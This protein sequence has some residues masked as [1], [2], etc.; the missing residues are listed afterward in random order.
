[1]RSRFLGAVLSAVQLLQLA[2]ARP[3]ASGAPVTTVTVSINTAVCPATYGLPPASSPVVVPYTTTDANGNVIVGSSTSYALL[4]SS[5]PI[6]VLYATTDSV[7]NVYTATTTSFSTLPTSYPY[8]VYFPTTDAAGRVGVGSST[9][10]TTLPSPITVTATTTNA[11]GSIITTT[12][13]SS[14]SVPT[15]VSFT[16]E[17]YSPEVIVYTTTNAAGMTVTTSSTTAVPYT[18]AP[19][20][21]PYVYTNAAGVIVTGSTTSYLPYSSPAATIYFT[22][23]NPDGSV[24]TGSSISY[25]DFIYTPPGVGDRGGIITPYTTTLP[26][27]QVVVQF[28]TSFPPTTAPAT[29]SAT[30]SA[31]TSTGPAPGGTSA[32]PAPTTSVTVFTTTDSQGSIITT[33]STSVFTPSIAPPSAGSSSSAAASSGS[34][35]SSGS[36][37][38]AGS[39]LSSALGSAGATSNPAFVTSTPNS[40][41]S[42][43]VISSTATPSPSATGICTKNTTA[44]SPAPS[45]HAPCPEALGSSYESNN[46]VEWDLFCTVDF[47]MNDVGTAYATSLRDC[48]SY[49]DTYIPTASGTFGDLPCVAVTFAS[50]NPNGANCYLKSSITTASYGSDNLDSAKLH[51][52]NPDIANISVSA[53]SSSTTYS[54]AG[55]TGT[56]GSVTSL[57]LSTSS[58]S[59]PSIPPSASPS[60]S[61]SASPSASSGGS[62][63]N[64]DTTTTTTTTSTAPT[65][66]LGGSSSS[67]AASSKSP[68]AAA[69]SNSP[70]AAASSNSPAAAASSSSP[71]AASANG[72][73]AAAGSSHAISRSAVTVT[74]T[75]TGG[76]TA[77]TV[78]YSTVYASG[79]ATYTADSNNVV[80]PDAAY[81]PCGN[82]GTYSPPAASNG[83]PTGVSKNY[84]TV[85]GH[86]YN[87]YCGYV[88]SGDDL[89]NIPYSSSTFSDCISYCDTYTDPNAGQA[90][91]STAGTCVAANWGAYNPNGA[92]CFLHIAANDIISSDPQYD[93]TDFYQDL[94]VLRTSDPGDSEYV[95]P[96][97]P[98]SPCDQYT[99][100]T[101][102]NQGS[103]YNA[104]GNTPFQVFCGYS[105]Q[106]GAPANSAVSGTNIATFKGCIDACGSQ[107]GCT[108]VTWA[109]ASPYPCYFHQSPNQ[110]AQ[111]AGYDSAWLESA[112]PNGQ[113][114]SPLVGPA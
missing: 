88:N 3:Q 65:P 113:P 106:G 36:G 53:Y 18:G 51:S 80:A 17:Y 100:G 42:P 61:S 32:T 76:G 87:L 35:A 67:G 1:M 111:V 93:A 16:Y 39:A 105:F 83:H 102:P 72:P 10:Y 7:G 33:S 31:T 70:A 63:S 28:S 101:Y 11:A 15:G 95:V 20:V 66:A 77:T 26:N 90:G 30:A 25:G 9:A 5:T 54:T 52:Y 99:N 75:T 104:N 45:S 110:A 86:S 56:G 73:A 23:T 29:A 74:T 19:T 94:A 79:A 57:T 69:S 108:A 107:A 34:P 55:G 109:T 13:L 114:E 62:S 97:D 84:Y 112:E 47:S 96:A 49:C 98:P 8:V 50:Y 37:G 27:G 14:F 2:T 85:N 43:I 82:Y 48:I 81:G 40:A 46:C 92:N 38:G 12:S 89:H 71:A 24:S 59:S 64:T 44:L 103:T 41:G 91:S 68:A 21:V 60:V 78:T 4:P 58:I 22:T 6:I